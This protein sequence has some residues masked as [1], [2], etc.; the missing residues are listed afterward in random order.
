[1][2]GKKNLE[3]YLRC[4][5]KNGIIDFS[6]RAQEIDGVISFYIHPDGKDGGTQ[7]YTVRGE[8]VKPISEWIY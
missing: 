1:M 8:N 2:T 7:D 5:L 3:E 6:I 4:E